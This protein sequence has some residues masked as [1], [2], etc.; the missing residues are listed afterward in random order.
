M[1]RSGK[2][3]V[4]IFGCNVKITPGGTGQIHPDLIVFTFIALAVGRAAH[5]QTGLVC[6][7]GYVF[8]HR[9]TGKVHAEFFLAG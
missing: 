3:H 1:G 9:S 7:H 5:V 2:D 8:G 6:I 4:P